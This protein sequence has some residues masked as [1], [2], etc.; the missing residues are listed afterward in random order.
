MLKSHD[1]HFLN[2]VEA[3]LALPSDDNAP[4]IHV[5]AEVC[6]LIDFFM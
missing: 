2:F 4:L 1:M 6:T 5:H 3:H